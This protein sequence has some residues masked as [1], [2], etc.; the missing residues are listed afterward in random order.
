M[1]SKCPVLPFVVSGRCFQ[2]SANGNK[3]KDKNTIQL[4]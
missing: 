4:S 3:E 1:I 2:S